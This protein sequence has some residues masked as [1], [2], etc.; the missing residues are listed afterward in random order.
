MSFDNVNREKQDTQNQN[1]F[2]QIKIKLFF[3][4]FDA[5]KRLQQV[6]TKQHESKKQKKKIN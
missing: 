2:V 6:R 3:V 1:E 4:Y 5:Q